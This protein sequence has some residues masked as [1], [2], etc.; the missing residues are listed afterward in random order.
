LKSRGNFHQNY[1]SVCVFMFACS[2]ETLSLKD[3]FRLQHI[4]SPCQIDGP[5]F[6]TGIFCGAPS[7]A[8]RGWHQVA[9]HLH[10]PNG[11]IGARL[12][13]P[14]APDSVAAIGKGLRSLSSSPV[15]CNHK[16]TMRSRKSVLDRIL[17][18][19]R[20]GKDVFSRLHFL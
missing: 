17:Y 9:R 1:V 18:R 4:F 11:T 12:A 14:L 19:V 16:Y 20:T 6:D 10:D 3:P 2:L 8:A 5:L 13:S 7:A 15:L